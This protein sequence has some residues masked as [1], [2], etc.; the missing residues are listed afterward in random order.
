MPNIKG[1]ISVGIAF[2]ASEQSLDFL[3]VLLIAFSAKLV[4][5]FFRHL[6]QINTYKRSFVLYIVCQ[7]VVLKAGQF[8]VK[9]SIVIMSSWMFYPIVIRAFDSIALLTICLL[10]LWIILFIILFSWFPIFFIVSIA[11]FM[12]NFRLSQK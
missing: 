5:P 3:Y 7:T 2:A 9:F 8:P 4:C 10:I 6:N 1:C 11:F 12:P